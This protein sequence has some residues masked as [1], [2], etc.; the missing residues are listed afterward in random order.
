LHVDEAEVYGDVSVLHVKHRI[1]DVPHPEKFLECGKDKI[2]SYEN[3][4]LG[5][6]LFARNGF[7]PDRDNPVAF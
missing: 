2:P 3:P 4:F 5:M 6:W 1:A 7:G